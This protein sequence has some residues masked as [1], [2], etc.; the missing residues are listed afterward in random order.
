MHLM[1]LVVVCYTMCSL[2]DKY[3]VAKLKMEGNAFTF[4]MAAPTSILL[5]FMLPFSDTHFILSWQAIL[6]VILI[7]VSKLL[8]FKLATI[9]LRE[10]SAFELKAWLGLCLFLSY[11]TDIFIGTSTFNIIK[12]IA[13]IVTAV[14]L[15][16]IAKSENEHINYKKIVIPLFFYLLAKYGYGM[17][18]TASTEY[19]SS[20]LALLFG[21]ILL[22]IVLIPF[23]KPITLFKTKFKGSMFVALTKIPNAIGLV[24]ENMVIAT[25][26]TNY[27]FIQPMIMVTLFFIGIIRKESTK[28]LNIIG[29]IICIIGILGFQLV[30]IL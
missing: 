1:L 10:M 16:M 23:A 7:A 9:I 28:L 25:S 21:L 19:I 17:I 13:I 18:I 12:I 29:G 8:E 6:A 24:L 3:S 27:A 4:L 20:Y 14:G 30:D 11:A 5:L 2:S 26:M 15:F 22:A